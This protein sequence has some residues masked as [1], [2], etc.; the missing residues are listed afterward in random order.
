MYKLT[1]FDVKGRAEITRLLFSYAGIPFVD[2]R[3]SRE[4]FAALKPSLPAGQVP[5]LTIDDSTVI[6]QVRC[7]RWERG[8]GVGTCRHAFRGVTGTPSR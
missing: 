1:Y 5:V 3:L 7:S 2:D 4:Q 6:P 8:V